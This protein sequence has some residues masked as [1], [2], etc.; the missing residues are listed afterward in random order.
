MRNRTCRRVGII[1]AGAAGLCA[2]R[3]ATA[4]GYETIVF[5]QQAALGGLWRYSS[6]PRAYSAVYEQM[7]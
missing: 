7:R 2:A 5:E 1:G 6:D 3:H 4:A